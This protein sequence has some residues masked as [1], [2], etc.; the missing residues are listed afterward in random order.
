MRIVSTTKVAKSGC[1]SASVSSLTATSPNIPELPFK[2][3]I[4]RNVIKRLPD[5]TNP[6]K[7]R[8]A[9]ARF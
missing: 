6:E 1:K 8:N 4:T 2:K 5:K 7:R 9:F 3:K